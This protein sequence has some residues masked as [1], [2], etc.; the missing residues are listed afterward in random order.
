MKKIYSIVV[1]LLSSIFASA[2]CSDLFFSEYSEGSSNNKYLEVYNPSGSSIDLSNYSIC[3]IGNGGSFTN[4][5]QLYGTLG[6]DKVFVVSTDQSDASAILSKADTALSFPSVAHFNGDDAICLLSGTD[7]IDVIGVR[8]VRENWTVGTGSTKD[9]TLVRKANV[10]AGETD[11]TKAVE[12]WDVYPQNTWSYLGSTTSDCQQSAPKGCSDLFFS[13]YSEGSSNNKYL[14]VYNPSGSSIDLSNYSI[15]VIG[16]GG[17][18]TNTF[19]LYG[20]LGSDKVFV[21]STDQS[22]ASAILSKA[23]TALSFPSVAHF[24]GDDAI[25]LLSGTDTIDV[26]GVRRVREN[27]TVGTGSTKDHTLVRKANVSAGETDWTKAVEQWD[28]YPQN[29]WSYLGSTTSDCHPAVTPEVQFAKTKYFVDENAGTAFVEVSIAT[30]SKDTTKVEV[31]VTGGTA[32]NGTD[33]TITSSTMVV[34]NPGDDTNQKVTMD[35]TDNAEGG[36]SKNI[37]LALRNLS[38]NAVWGSDTTSEVVI[39]ND[40]YIV[41]DIVDVVQLDGDLAP[42]N[43]GVKYEIT[44]VVYGIDYDGNAGLSFTAIDATS[45]INIF[46][47]NDVSDY[48]VTEGDEITVRGEIE[49][50]NGLLELVADSIKLNSQG[51]TLASPT[52]VDAPSEETESEFIQLA[53]VWITNDTTTVWPSNQNV[54][55]TNANMDTF[56]IR[57]DKDILDMPGEAIIADTMVITGIGGQYD[58]NAPYNSGY[59]IFPRKLSDVAAWVDRSSVSELTVIC[60]VY[61][62]PTA[63]NLT[64]IGTDKW[65]LYEVY[66]VTGIKVSEGSFVN[67]NLSVANLDSGNYIIRMRSA[68]KVGIARFMIVR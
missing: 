34:F 35:I 11:W 55:L 64:V 10:S 29:T 8:R 14:E 37:T 39:L 17:S 40:D 45:G 30:T 58:R 53:K 67:N 1:L 20:T 6:S 43:K 3:V 21:V 7:T 18:F 62:N 5:F 49:S 23:D 32:V 59:Q 4:T 61:P 24:N 65:D 38:S 51:N 2:Q 33:Y 9:H 28:V 16:N 47:F 27:W 22:D 25:C 13:E 50:Y 26:I 57:I 66:S 36:L 12:Q 48:V 19:Q 44:G 41:S 63:E 46:N 68:D 31:F 42:T 56:Q 15:C 60:K 52:V 54:E